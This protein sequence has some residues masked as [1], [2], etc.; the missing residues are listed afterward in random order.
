MTMHQ[1][2]DNCVLLALHRTRQVSMDAKQNVDMLAIGYT[3]VLYGT[4][5]CLLRS[6][7]ALNKL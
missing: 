2:L 4:S 7:F 6:A 1:L 5:T 3:T